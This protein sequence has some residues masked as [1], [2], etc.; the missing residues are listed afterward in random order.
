MIV[1]LFLTFLYAVQGL[2]ESLNVVEKPLSILVCNFGA[3]RGAN[4]QFTG[5]TDISH[6]AHVIRFAIVSMLKH[7]GSFPRKGTLRI[8]Y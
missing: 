8:H 4:A 2:L 7:L 5:S 3:G 1:Y 6:R